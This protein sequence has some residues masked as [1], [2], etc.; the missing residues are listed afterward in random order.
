MATK[1]DLAALAKQYAPMINAKITNTIHSKDDV[2]RLRM[3]Q[4]A[5]EVEDLALK[6]GLA[7]PIQI[8]PRHICPHP[9]NRHISMLEA[10]D[11][12]DLLLIFY[13]Q[14][15]SLKDVQRRWTFEKPHGKQGEV[16]GQKVLEL[17]RN[18][19][20]LLPA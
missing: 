15:F 8:H 12:H 13:D 3:K 1:G 7:V 6:H 4:I 11:C 17:I 14:G 2:R 9:E 5:D 16:F 10:G 20:G 18:A 19:G